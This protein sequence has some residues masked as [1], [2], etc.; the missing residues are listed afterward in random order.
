MKMSWH[1]NGLMFMK[2]HISLDITYT[3]TNMKKS[4]KRCRIYPEDGGNRF[5][6]NFG[7]C[8]P[9]YTVSHHGCE[10]FKSHLKALFDMCQG[11]LWHVSRLSVTCVKALFDICQGSLWHVKALFD[12]CQDATVWTHAHSW[13]A[14]FCRDTSYWVTLYSRLISF[15]KC[16]QHVHETDFTNRYSDI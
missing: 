10:K 6:R 1:D 13:H 12:M 8:L 2:Q 14:I 7:M 9:N 11:S 15:T 16:A 3:H 5:F 4:V